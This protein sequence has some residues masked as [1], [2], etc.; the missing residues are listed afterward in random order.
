[1]VLKGDYGMRV[2]LKPKAWANYLMRKIIHKYSRYPKSERSDFGILANHSVAKQF[3]LQTLSEIR[4]KSVRF[5][6]FGCYFFYLVYN[7]TFGFWHYWHSLYIKR[8]NPNVLM[9]RTKF[10]SVCQT[11]RS[12][13]RASLYCEKTRKREKINE[14]WHSV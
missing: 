13:F 12:V 4:T 7:R 8:R 6:M 2:K 3:G 11:E 5:R 1:M 14:N 9:N 10:S